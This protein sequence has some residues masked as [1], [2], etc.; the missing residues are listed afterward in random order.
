MKKFQFLL[1][2]AGPI[3]KLFSL[4]IWDDFIQRCD[5]TISRIITEDQALYTDDGTKQ[6]NLKPYEEKDLINIID[7]EFSVVKTF[8]DRFKLLYQA[9]IHDGEKETLAFL[10]DSSENWLVCS[11]DGV[12]FRVLGLLG[13]AN[14]GI[15]LEE[16][17]QKVGLSRQNLEWKY[18]KKFCEKHT[19]SGQI[20]SIQDKGLL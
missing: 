9:D 11:S 19:R 12:V 5:V 1:L 2:D 18:T 20:D 8:Y 6:I 13:K 14:Q 3:I 10:C 16:I 7:I 4:G 15:S 17:L